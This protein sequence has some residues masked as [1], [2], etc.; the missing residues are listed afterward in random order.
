[1]ILPG[2]DFAALFM[3]SFRPSDAAYKLNHES[4]A[5]EW[6]Y[7]PEA[8]QACLAVGGESLAFIGVNL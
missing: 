6:M 3:Q 1:M 2:A 4:F 8:L 7:P 5:S